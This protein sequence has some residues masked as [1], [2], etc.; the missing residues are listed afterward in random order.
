MFV[1]SFENYL[2]N[3]D[4]VY[5]FGKE[6]ADP[7]W[8]PASENKKYAIVMIDIDGDVTPL[9]LYSTKEICDVAY[10]DLMEDIAKGINLIKVT[11]EKEVSARIR[12]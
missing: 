11:S 2:Y 8:F 9:E 7:E 6:E 5:C 12:H 1:K 10:K 3:A 4:N